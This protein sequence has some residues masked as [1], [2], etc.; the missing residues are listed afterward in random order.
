VTE[1]D[2]ADLFERYHLALFRYFLRLTGRREDAEDL[3]QDLFERVTRRRGDY[4]RRGMGQE[5]VWLFRIARHLIIDKYR[6]ASKA[7]VR[8]VNAD[9]IGR[10]GTQL[11]AFGLQEALGLVNALDRHIFVLREVVG[12]T[13]PEIADVCELSEDGVKARLFRVRG[14]LRELLGG[15]LRRRE[16]Q[17]RKEDAGP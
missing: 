6:E 17:D 13:Y 2:V 4:R 14:Q 12:L 7:S 11:I 8:T 16:N 3:T 9:R 1:R 5:T 10:D 15:R